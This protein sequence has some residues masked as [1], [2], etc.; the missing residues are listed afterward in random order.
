MEDLLLNPKIVTYH[1]ISDQKNLPAHLALYRQKNIVVTI[2]DG[3][4]SFYHQLFPL[5]KE[6]NIK[7]IL[8]IVTSLIDT[9]TPFWWDE[10]V[11][12]LGP[13]EGEKMTWE[14][15]KWPNHKRVS[16]LE[17]LRKATDKPALEQLQLSTKQL[18]EMQQAGVIIANHSHTHPMFDQCTE[19]E[20]RDEFRKSRQFFQERGLEGY[21]LFAY[22]NGNH[23]ELAEKVAREEGIKFAFMFD[24][25]LPSK[26][27][28]PFRM[29]R[30]SVTDDTSMNKLRFILSGIH[31]AALPYIKKVHEMIRG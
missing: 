5:L 28:N 7:P 9:K 1:K 18:L 3:D 30:L 21:E 29:S 4:I 26:E 10:L 27:F 13:Q 8:F 19:E 11:Y 23:S 15:K 14:V 24:H 31:S 22:P 20:L 25:K 6:F 17:A 16:Y 2:D 12:L